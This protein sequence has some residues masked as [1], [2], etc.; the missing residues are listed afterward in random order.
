MNKRT[1]ERLLPLAMKALEDTANCKICTNKEKREVPS[2]YRSQISAF[3]AAITMG[4]FKAAVAYFSKD[5]T[6]GTRDERVKRSNLICILHY[7]YE[8]WDAQP[9]SMDTSKWMSTEEVCE[10]VLQA[11]GDILRTMQDRYLH[12]AVAVKLAMN[13]FY[14]VKRKSEGNNEQS[15]SET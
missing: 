13:A 2:E 9:N 4:S 7:L 15:A 10:E 14:L 1:V 11:Q 5:A 12:A 6:T 8:N 3:G